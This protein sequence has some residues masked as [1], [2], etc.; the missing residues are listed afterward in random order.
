MRGIIAETNLNKKEFLE[1][2]DLAKKYFNDPKKKIL[3]YVGEI[4]IHDC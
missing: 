4:S 1:L 2:I 3:W